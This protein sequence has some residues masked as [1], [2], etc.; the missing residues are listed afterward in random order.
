M[1]HIFRVNMF[2]KDL[3]AFSTTKA[4]EFYVQKCF[5]ARNYVAWITLNWVRAMWRNA[6]LPKC[7]YK[8]LLIYA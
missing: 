2:Q 7:R 8:A 6:N 3:S 5:T 1:F 4:V